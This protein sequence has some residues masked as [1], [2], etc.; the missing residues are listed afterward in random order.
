MKGPAER[1][2]RHHRQLDAPQR[3]AG[4]VSRRAG[5]AQHGDEIGG[6]RRHGGDGERN[7]VDIRCC[8]FEHA[9]QF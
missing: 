9:T 4:T 8:R 5:D 3:R 6:G 1:L 2:R 7:P